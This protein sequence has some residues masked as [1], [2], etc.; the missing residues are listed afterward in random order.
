MNLH[1]QN[2][3]FGPQLVSR[4]VNTCS[5]KHMLCKLPANFTQDHVSTMTTVDCYNMD[6]QDL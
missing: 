5:H 3:A 2:L 1:K 4:T 6:L